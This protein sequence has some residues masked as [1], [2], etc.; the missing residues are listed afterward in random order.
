MIQYTQKEHSHRKIPQVHP[1]HVKRGVVQC[2]FKREDF[3]KGGLGDREETSIQSFC[4]P[5]RF[6]KNSVV[7]AGT[8]NKME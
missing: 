3:D 6:V 5:T 2:L 7:R 1:E 8:S 4:N